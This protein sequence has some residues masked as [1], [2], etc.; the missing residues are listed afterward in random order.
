MV[1]GPRPRNRATSPATSLVFAEGG[2]PL[3]VGRVD[4][5]AVPLDVPVF[6]AHREEDRLLVERV[7]DLAGRRRLAVEEPALAEL[8]C[9]AAL[10]LHPHAAAVDE[11]ELVLSV[12]VVE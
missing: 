6:A 1:T 7:R 5:V 10:D 12:V 9:L 4:E 2:A 11:V 3:G 8:A